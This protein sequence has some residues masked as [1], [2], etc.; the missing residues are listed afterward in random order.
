MAAID[1]TVIVFKNGKWMKNPYYF[2]EN[3]NYISLLPFEY[4][5]D[6][7]IHK[8]G[9]TDIYD[10]IVWYRD[11]YDRLYERKGLKKNRNRRFSLAYFISR[12]DWIFHRM[13]HVCYK[14]EVG[15]YGHNNIEVYIYHDPMKGSYASFYD[16]ESDAY[17]VLGGYGH[18]NNVYTHFMKR[19]YGNEFEEK[20]AKEAYKWLCTDILE[21]IVD[22]I[23][24]GEDVHDWE[25]IDH[26]KRML[27]KVFMPELLE[28]NQI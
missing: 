28:A 11:E 17:V 1:H 10:D 22:S 21:E 16:D 4:G 20:M 3:D 26:K 8:I 9:N 19:G 27:R 13:D 18:Y 2:D 23:A 7:N 5:R 12:I 6:G 25:I 15:T 14:K 24:S